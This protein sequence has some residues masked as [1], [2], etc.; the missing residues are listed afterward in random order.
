MS[1]NASGITNNLT[2][3]NLIL[4]ELFNIMSQFKVGD[5]VKIICGGFEGEAAT[6]EGFITG[7]S[8][9]KVK[10]DNPGAIVTL[11]YMESELEMIEQ[12]PKTK[13]VRKYASV[14]VG[15]NGTIGNVHGFHTQENLTSIEKD[16][17]QGEKIYHIVPTIFEDVE[18]PVETETRWKFM[19]K[20]EHSN[21]YTTDGK[22]PSLE[23]AKSCTCG[24]AIQ[25]ID[26]SAEEFE[27]E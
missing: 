9:I 4:Q 22:Y 20:D 8:H 11:A 17:F 5:R 10:R 19:C 25:K 2:T 27:I 26:D 6:V 24:E 1:D 23:R 13:T 7:S 14:C 3:T 18:V 12:K 16:Y 15:D 21:Y